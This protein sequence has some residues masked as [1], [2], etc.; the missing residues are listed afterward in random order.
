ME[1][2]RTATGKEFEC[3]YFNP[4]IP[5]KQ[6]NLRVNG[7]SIVDVA[8]IFSNSAETANLACESASVSGYTK[9]KAI[10]PEGDAIRVVLEQE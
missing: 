4:C 9:L 3:D 6:T 2:L 8:E 10:I 7:V 1:K 5:V